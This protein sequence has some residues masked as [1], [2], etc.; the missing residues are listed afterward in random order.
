LKALKLNIDRFKPCPK[1]FEITRGFS[2]NYKNLEKNFLNL[3]LTHPYLDVS[4]PVQSFE[5]CFFL[6]SVV[7]NMLSYLRISSSVRVNP[8]SGGYFDWGFSCTVDDQVLGCWGSFNPSLLAFLDLKRPVLGA[9]FDLDL[10]VEF[11]SSYSKIKDPVIYP[12]AYRD[13]TVST[14]LLGHELLVSITSLQ[15]PFLTDVQI[16]DYLPNPELPKFTLRFKF[17]SNQ[18][19]LDKSLIDELIRNLVTD[20]EKIAEGKVQV[21]YKELLF[22]Q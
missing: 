19:T 16:V 1:L 15:I 11:S 18:K 14:T 5:S 20:L 2:A 21:L 8:V 13:L 7:W 12:P 10:L 6:A 3:A 17:Q 4:R 9:T 22:T